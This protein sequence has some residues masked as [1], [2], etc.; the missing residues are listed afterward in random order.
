[1]SS[2]TPPSETTAL[3]NYLQHI[4]KTAG[5]SWVDTMSGPMSSPTWTIDGVTIAT[6]TGS[7]KREAREAA[8]GN[9][10]QVFKGSD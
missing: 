9:A 6:G 7:T 1:M 3:N 4:G 2:G 8:A 5:H 10:L